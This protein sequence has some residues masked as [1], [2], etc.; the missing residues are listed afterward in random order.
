MKK[1]KIRF[2]VE[3]DM[4]TREAILAVPC[5]YCKSVV[6]ERCTSLRYRGGHGRKSNLSHFHHDREAEAIGLRIVSEAT[7][8]A[9]KAKA[10]TKTSANPWMDVVNSLLDDPNTPDFSK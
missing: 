2:T 7:V 4:P 6:G 10:T 8:Y 3:F 5:A 1:A 9:L